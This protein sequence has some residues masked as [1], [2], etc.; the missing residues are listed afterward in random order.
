MSGRWPLCVDAGLP[1]T[2]QLYSLVHT[3]QGC[4]YASMDCVGWFPSLDML[5]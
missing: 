5:R 2:V 1:D 4:L 3:P